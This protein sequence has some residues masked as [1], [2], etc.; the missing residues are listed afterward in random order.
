MNDKINYLIIIDKKSQL[1]VL[2]DLLAKFKIKHKELKPEE[3]E[4]IRWLMLKEFPKH[5]KHNFK[6]ET[7]ENLL[8]KL[9]EVS[10]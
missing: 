10:K 6:C 4:H 5:L 3:L 7:C 2:L 1:A 9:N 8:K